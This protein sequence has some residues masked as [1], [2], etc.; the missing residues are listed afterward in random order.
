MAATALRAPDVSCL[1]KR[2]WGHLVATGR[3]SIGLDKLIARSASC[4]AAMLELERDL[5]EM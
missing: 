3:P 1:G 4:S 5:F 2:T